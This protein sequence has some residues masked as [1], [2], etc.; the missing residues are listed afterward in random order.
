MTE[1]DTSSAQPRTRLFV[2]GISRLTSEERIK[3]YFERF[4][5]ILSVDVVKDEFGQSRGFAFIE[6]AE[7]G[8]VKE[9]LKQFH[10]IDRKQ[11][12]VK[13]AKPHID[14]GKESNLKSRWGS[15]DLNIRITRL[16]DETTEEEIEQAL[17]QYGHVQS[18][19]ITLNEQ[20]N[21]LCFALLTDL[22]DSARLFSDFV[23]IH[24]K[25]VHIATSVN[26]KFKHKKS[27]LKLNS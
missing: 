16:H 27:F 7:D 24:G 26:T 14:W 13:V 19:K 5:T 15:G 22:A 12:D 25:R 20:G 1:Q 8:A 6:V 21:K 17:A 4:A 23:Y 11:L 3:Q 18:I 9:I 2:G 10:I